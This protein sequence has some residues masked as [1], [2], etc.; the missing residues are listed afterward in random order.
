MPVEVVTPDGS[1]DLAATI[2]EP[3]GALVYLL[4]YGGLRWGE[5]V[6]VRRK[7]CD[8]LRSRIEV[9]ESLSEARGMLHFGATKTYRHRTVIVPA[10]LSELMA[11]HLARGVDDGPD[12]LVF[13][14]PLGRPLRNSNFRR[15]V[16]YKA[17]ADAGLPEGLRIHDPTTPARRC[18]SP[19]ERIPKRSRCTL[20]TH[21]FR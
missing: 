2:R 15:Q 12:E 9:T 18:S 8:L 7:R 17:V 3:Y 16:W 10:F 13:T 14:S 5:A 11:G 19:R 4:A 1:S 21:R 20:V 6:A